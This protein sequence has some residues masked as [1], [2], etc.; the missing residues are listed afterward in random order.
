M[1]EVRFIPT[2]GISAELAVDYLMLENVASVGGSWITP[3][4]L[5]EAGDFDGIGRIAADAAQLGL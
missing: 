2:G 3:K 5:I 4:G 1:P